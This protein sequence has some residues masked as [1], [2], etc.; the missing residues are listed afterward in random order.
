MPKFNLAAGQVFLGAKGGFGSA[1]LMSVEVAK[2]LTSP[3]TP[4][5]GSIREMTREVQ[6][7]LRYDSSF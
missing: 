7:S 4:L 6:I 1:T 5:F 2:R 3:S